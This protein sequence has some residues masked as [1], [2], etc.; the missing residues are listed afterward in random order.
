VLLWAKGLNAKDIHKEVFPVYSGKCFPRKAVHDWVNKFSQGRS[1]FG[2]D[3][4]RS[5]EVTESRVERLLCCVF[6]RIG[7]M[8]G[9]VYQCWWRICREINIFLR[10]EYH[11]FYV[12][13]PFVTL[14]LTLP[15]MMTRAYPVSEMLSMLNIFQTMDY[16]RNSNRIMIRPFPH[17]DCT[18]IL[19]GR[20]APG[21]NYITFSKLSKYYSPNPKTAQ[22][23]RSK[24]DI[25]E[26]ARG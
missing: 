13:Y 3:P 10:F 11:E 4:R 8:M 21:Q 2:D 22:E 18:Q 25:Q 7:K 20:V 23:C 1:K 9:Q 5:A 16:V 17:T 12:L 6:R 19:S 26:I 24:Q 14:F 15:R